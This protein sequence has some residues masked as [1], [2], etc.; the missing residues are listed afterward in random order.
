MSNYDSSK[1]ATPPEYD[2]AGERAHDEDCACDECREDGYC[3]EEPDGYDPFAPSLEELERDAMSACLYTLARNLRDASAL[4]AAFW[5][6]WEENEHHR[7]YAMHGYR[8]DQAWRPGINLTN[9]TCA[10]PA[11]NGETK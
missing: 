6:G 4:C 8:T 1:L 11:G 2:E 3:D 10:R 9:P 5:E 7:L